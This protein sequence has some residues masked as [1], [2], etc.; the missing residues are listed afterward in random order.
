MKRTKTSFRN[1]NLDDNPEVHGNCPICG[2]RFRVS[3][4]AVNHAVRCPSCRQLFYA[5]PGDEPLENTAA[6]W[7]SQ[8]V[9]Q[10][11]ET[12]SRHRKLM[13]ILKK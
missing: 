1:T 4:Q 12:R 5:V 10:L 8:D 2:G 7:I 13:K 3:V 11:A 9:Q 6:Q